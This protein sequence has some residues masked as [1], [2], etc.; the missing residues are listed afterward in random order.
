MQSKKLTGLMIL[1]L[2]LALAC[3]VL[4]QPRGGGPGTGQGPMGPRFYDTKTVTTVKG[5]VEKLETA[6]SM[7]RRGR[8]G[9]QWQELVLK[10]DK[11]TLNVHLGP[12]GYAREQGLEPKVG[13]VIEVTGSKITRGQKTIL[14]ASEIKAGDKVLKLRDEQ[15]F[16]LWRGWR[17]GHPRQGKQ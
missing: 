10:T 16:P 15:G 7:G 9:M 12:V 13:D 17:C 6:P 2:T 8:K 1:A 14:L 4:A 11:E 5:T 3:P